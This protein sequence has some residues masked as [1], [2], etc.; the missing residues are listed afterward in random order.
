MSG[1]A[2]AF[3]FRLWFFD[4]CFVFLGGGRPRDTFVLFLVYVGKSQ[5]SYIQQLSIVVLVPGTSYVCTVYI[6]CPCCS[7]GCLRVQA[8]VVVSRLS[9]VSSRELSTNNTL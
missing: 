8:S 2:R 1:G 3:S 5:T 9:A 4:V 7:L 6:H